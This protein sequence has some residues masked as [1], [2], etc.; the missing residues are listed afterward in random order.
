M[1]L[2]LAIN[3]TLLENPE[4]SAT[5]CNSWTLSKFSCLVACSSTIMRESTFCTCASHYKQLLTKHWLTKRTNC[6]QWSPVSICSMLSAELAIMT[7]CSAM[8]LPDEEDSWDIVFDKENACRKREVKIKVLIEERSKMR[9][10]HEIRFL[11]IL[12]I[13][14]HQSDQFRVLC[15]CMCVC[16]C[17]CAISQ[18]QHDA[19]TQ[20]IFLDW[21]STTLHH[22]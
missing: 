4:L 12:W 19:Q 9:S 8:S 11:F 5:S 18:C 6:C 2:V 10:E 14:K 15:V 1:Q 7:T 13:R 3:S 20:W 22:A 17:V 16:V 21:V